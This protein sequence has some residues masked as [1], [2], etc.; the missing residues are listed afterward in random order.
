MMFRNSRKQTRTPFVA[1]LA[2]S[3]SLIAAGVAM[4]ELM[5]LAACPLCVVQRMLYLLMAVLAALAIPV[6]NW[7]FGRRFLATCLALTAGGGTLVAGYQ[8]WIQRFSPMTTCSGRLS[9]WEEIV[10]SAGNAVPLLFRASGLCSDPAWKFLG[11]SIAEW[12]LLAFSALLIVA[13][14]GFRFR[15]SGR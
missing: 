14:V 10:E 6:A 3:M 1:I 15:Q 13:I 9:W 11:L 2:V 8:A 12:S 5:Q 7:R 4:S